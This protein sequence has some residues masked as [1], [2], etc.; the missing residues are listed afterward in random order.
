MARTGRPP[1]PRT[2][3][4][5][6]GCGA[7]MERKVSEV[8]S[9]KRLFCTATC[10][11]K[12]GL[13]PRT[14]PSRT[15]ERCGEE[16]RASWAGQ[17]GRFCSK[18]CYGEASRTTTDRICAQ[19]GEV[20]G[21]PAG[22]PDVYC[23][24]ACYDEGRQTPVGKRKLN[25]DGYAMVYEPQHPNAHPSTG[26]VLEHRKVMADHLGRPLLPEENPHH[27]GA[28]DDN[29]LEKLQLWTTSQPPGNRVEEKAEWAREMLA[30]YGTPAEQSQFVAHLPEG[31]Q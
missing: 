19:C 23:S 18:K 4:E 24:R 11:R 27:L 28:K 26:W 30:L 5:C 9:G 3:T 22:D 12:T 14:L 1:A 25:S 31:L 29:R 10:A 2:L 21:K 17:V 15:C 13:R 16:F 8:E 20:F 7:S 6:A